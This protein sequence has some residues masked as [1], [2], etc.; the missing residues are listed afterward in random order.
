MGPVRLSDVETAQQ[1]I[2]NVAK[3]LESEGK[4]IIS[5]GSDGDALV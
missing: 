4:I 1:E 2:V 5:R 3:R